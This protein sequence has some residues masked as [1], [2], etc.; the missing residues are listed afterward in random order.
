MTMSAP[1][2][3]VWPGKTN[4]QIATSSMRAIVPGKYMQPD[5]AVAFL[6]MN[7]AMQ[8]DIGKK[9]TLSPEQDAYRSLAKQKALYA[10]HQKNPSGTPSAAWP[11]TSNHGFGL[12]V[13]V[14][15]MTN[16]TIAAWM[17]ENAKKYHYRINRIKSEPWH[18]EYIGPITD[19]AGDG[20][21]I[22]GEDDMI[23]TQYHHVNG[24]DQAVYLVTPLSVQ[25]IQQAGI[26]RDDGKAAFG[27]VRVDGPDGMKPIAA[28]VAKN[29]EV[30]RGLLPTGGGGGAPIDVQAIAQAVDAAL[31]DDVQKILTAIAGVDEATLATFGLK[32]A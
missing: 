8:K 7:A 17:R 10:A 1:A 15:G 30:L 21:P 23:A 18:I 29:L 12:A 4:G 19:L 26:S 13:D 20:S 14:T 27:E 25:T 2:T 16:S 5:A 9:L 3:L 6:A 24:K 22:K 11:G 28:A 31:Q 32:R